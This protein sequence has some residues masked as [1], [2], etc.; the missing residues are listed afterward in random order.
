LP[1]GC[2][3]YCMWMRRRKKFQHSLCAKCIVRKN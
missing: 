2:C 1:I 3:I